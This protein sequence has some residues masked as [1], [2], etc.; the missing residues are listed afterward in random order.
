M[1]FQIWLGIIFSSIQLSYACI[2]AQW[3]KGWNTNYHL[4][5]I[6]YKTSFSMPYDDTRFN[7]LTNLGSCCLFQ[8]SEDVLFVCTS[9][10][11]AYVCRW[12]KFCSFNRI[13]SML[14]MIRVVK[15][16]QAVKSDRE[17]L[18]ATW[19]QADKHYIDQ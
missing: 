12:C 3:F 2:I 15:C 19:V 5:D 14:L 18:Y 9:T 10:A 13:L 1:I 16:P 17:I 11:K 7:T 6:V 8:F 4:W